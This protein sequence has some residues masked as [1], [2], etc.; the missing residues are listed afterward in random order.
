MLDRA[1]IGGGNPVE[2]GYYLARSAW[3]KGYATELAS[4][5]IRYGFGAL[6]LDQ[7]VAVILPENVASGRVLEKAG[8]CHAGLTDYNG[9]AVELYAIDR[10]G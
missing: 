8:L 5:L 3:G 10:P 7:I 6:G 1:P 9:H 4:G 2:I